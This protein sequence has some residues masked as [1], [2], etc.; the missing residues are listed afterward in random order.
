MTVT[1][2]VFREDKQVQ[3]ILM[4]QDKLSIGRRAECDIPIKDPAVSGNHAEIEYVGNGYILRD[5]GSTNGVHVR[6]RQIQE[7]ALKNE[8]LV[9]IGEHQL[10]V[11]IP[12]NATPPT[13]ASPKEN[14]DESVRDATQVR[15]KPV[16]NQTDGYLKFV[17]G[18]EPGEV[19]KLEES[20]VT[21]GVPG[22][23][24]AAVSKRPHGHFIIHVDGGKD[25]N[26]TP[27]VNGEEI[28]FKS[29]RLEVG[30]LIEVADIQLEYCFD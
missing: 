14:V 26:K 22:V 19:V 6:G 17:K 4:E 11:L 20:L 13:K 23:Q 24:V 9:T 7:Y 2:I 28:G 8:D 27:V 21:I 25:R 1:I 5:L 18:G 3:Q 29:R 12:D 15:A 16:E 10:R 30:D